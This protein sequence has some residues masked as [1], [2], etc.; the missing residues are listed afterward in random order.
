M[1]FQLAIEIE[2]SRYAESFQ[3]RT[4]QGRVRL[5]APH[6]NPHFAKGTSGRGLLQNAPRDLL[7]FAFHSRSAHQ[8]GGGRAA[9]VRRALLAEAQ[10]G[11]ARAHLGSQVA[12]GQR[13]REVGMPPK[14]RD[15]PQFRIGQ[16]VEAIQPDRFDA[17]RAFAVNLFRGVRQPPG[18]QS[19]APVGH[20]AIH[21]P[22]NCQERLAQ[23]TGR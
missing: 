10:R 9:R 5:R 20:G 11:K 17:A 15:H 21:F 12:I 22:V 3:C 1:L 23:R 14:R 8:H 7:H 16:S 13:Q 4:Q 18:A 2:S 6:H 19:Q